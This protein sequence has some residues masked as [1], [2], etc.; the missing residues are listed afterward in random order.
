VD[1]IIETVMVVVVGA[2]ALFMARRYFG[3]VSKDG[4]RRLARL[5]FA[6]LPGSRERF[7]GTYKGWPAGYSQGSEST[8]RISVESDLGVVETGVEV[9]VGLGFSAPAMALVERSDSTW[10]KIP[11][12][13]RPA[14]VLTTGDP[15]FDQRFAL[16][17]G[18]PR[19]AEAVFTPEL[20]AA[21]LT[22]PLVLLVQHED[23]LLFPPLFDGTKIYE[24]YGLNAQ[25]LNAIFD[26]AHIFL[27]CTLL[28]ATQMGT[29]WRGAG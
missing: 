26:K 24:A 9:W 20:R 6:P 21:L 17:C 11:Q 22:Y 12:N 13:L 2:L 27:D 4:A 7:A 8:A 10:Q 23:R 14:Q 25:D 1:W 28:V 29:A 3:R 5:G 15:V 19:W 18:D 16:F